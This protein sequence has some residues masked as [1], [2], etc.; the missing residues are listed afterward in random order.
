MAFLK[1]TINKAVQILKEK[2]DTENEL[3]EKLNNLNNYLEIDKHIEDLK[4]QFNKFKRFGERFQK[5]EFKNEF[6]ITQRNVN[7]D[8]DYLNKLKEKNL[9][10]DSS[11]I[12]KNAKN[13]KQIEINSFINNLIKQLFSP[14]EIDIDEIAKVMDYIYK[15]KNF[16]K[17]FLD[18]FISSKKYTFYVFLNMNNLQILANIINAIN[19]SKKK[20][21]DYLYNIN[22]AIIYISEKTYCKHYNEKIFLCA[23][24][25]QNKFYKSK[26]FWI[27]LIEFKLARRLEEHLQHLQSIEIK[28]EKNQS[29]F[30]GAFKIFNK[31]KNNNYLVQTSG[32]A[33]KINGYKNLADNKKPL[34][35]QFAI[36]EIEIILK[37]Y[38]SHMC[39]F[40]LSNENTID[41]VINISNKF[42]FSKDMIN[43]FVNNI[44]TWF[45]SI[46][47]KLPED[48][49]DDSIKQK[50]YEIK[51]SLNIWSSNYDDKNEE[52]NINNHSFKQMLTII[53]ESS[54]F[55][56][57]NE[58]H[59]IFCLSKSIGK[60][61]RKKIFRE[62]LQ[63]RNLTI[64]DRLKI[65]KCLLSI[66][67]LVKKYDYR[68][69]IEKNEYEEKLSNK[70]KN[71]IFM[72]IKR[73]SFDKKYIDD[74][75]KALTNILNVIAFLKPELNYCQ[76]MSF[77]AAFLIQITSNEE[78][79]FYLMFGIVENTE[80][81]S[82]FISDLQ[83]LKIFFYDFDRL[84]AI[85]VPE[86][87][88][89]MTIN[90]IKVNYFCTS[91]FLTMFSNSASIVDKNNPPKIILKIWDEY[92][93]KGWKAFL[94]TGLIIMRVNE[95]IM[96]DLKPEQILQFL[97][98]DVLKSD[99][100]DEGIFELYLYLSKK[101]Y[102][103]NKLLRNLESEYIYEKNKKKNKDE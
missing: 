77:I 5:D 58:I 18:N 100:F 74:Y 61:V 92:F 45:Y 68:K 99:F 60:K 14:K 46:K 22:S 70:V 4:Q 87:Y 10:I 37:E 96:K 83:R 81:T 41:I 33:K 98:S 48:S 9:N 40:N 85:M 3:I 32:L 21:I 43:F 64:T 97:V 90:N 28:T 24:L 102:I 51:N 93:V 30:F 94:T 52:K 7:L 95:E 39:N 31:D 15:E 80:F 76:G 20:E 88:S 2:I 47:K 65:W 63:R 8:L 49:R 16:S 23:I 34:L 55:L 79:T 54:K 66:T 72:D 26:D 103:K 35:D 73:T 57:L 62:F 44:G 50:I 38:I 91:W 12:E 71:Q 56:P 29:K 75:K 25:S 89:I 82:I 86:A 1:I 78:E 36:N 17:Q 42:N 59:K 53:I 101:F 6:G 69:I 67:S 13:K 27:E 11:N 19:I 84:I